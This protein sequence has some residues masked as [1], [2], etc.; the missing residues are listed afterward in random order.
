VNRSSNFFAWLFLAVWAT[1]LCALSGYLAQFS[2]LG[3]WAPQL[4]TALFV[5]LAARVHVSLIPKLALTIGLARVAVSIDTPAAVLAAALSAGV[6]LRIARSVVQ[7]E[8]PVISGSL[9]FLLALLE[10]A[11]FEFVHTQ[12]RALL[13]EDRIV[14]DLAWRAGL[15]TAIATA[16]LGVVLVNLP[17][18]G[19]LIRRKT[20]AVGA[21]L[22]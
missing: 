21:S 15:S 3:R 16:L 11:W 6:L 17:G 2:W 4:Q 19:S 8:S 9:A 22:R 18:V 13:V 10:S 20:W 14:F 1:W 7:V 5:A 12:T